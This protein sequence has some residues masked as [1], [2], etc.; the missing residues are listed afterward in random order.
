MLE[1]DSKDL[2][3]VVNGKAAGDPKL[4]EA[5]SSMRDK[6]H[7]VDVR[8]TWEYGDAQRLAAEAVDDGVGIVV[9]A[10][11]DGTV[12]EVATGMLQDNAAPNSCL[13][14]LPYGTA[15]DLATSLGIPPRDPLAGFDVICAATPRPIDVGIV[16]GKHFV[17]MVTAGFGAEVTAQTPLEMKRV[18][19][20]A[21]YS[22]TGLV[23]AAKMN[24]W[25]IK[26]RLPDA[27]VE[28]DMIVLAVGNGRLA[29]GGYK[30]A[31][32]AHMDDGLL[33]LI[34]IHDIELPRI[35]ELLTELN[36]VQ[37]PDNSFV[38]YLQIP[39]LKVHSDEPIQ[40]NLDGEPIR[41]TEFAFELLPKCLNILAPVQTAD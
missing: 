38:H 18:L 6:G 30:L 35:G 39:S 11:G 40:M 37:N 15:N 36:D 8:V 19:R 9:A 14:I 28:G 5:V 29:G 26:V 21:A 4:R 12:N 41:D 24:S 10:G 25:K 7:K 16:N 23:M 27:E 20:G 22:L 3:L 1:K 31:P 32:H 17:N 33:D 13:G 34:V 2:R